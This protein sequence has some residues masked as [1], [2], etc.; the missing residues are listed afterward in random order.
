[1]SYEYLVIMNKY[2]NFGFQILIMISVYLHIIL[3]IIG[4][5]SI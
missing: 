1:M 2:K 5:E 3:Y 4:I